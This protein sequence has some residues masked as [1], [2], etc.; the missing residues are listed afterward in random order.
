MPLGWEPM[1][2]GSASSGLTRGRARAKSVWSLVAAVISW[3]GLMHSYR[4]TVADTVVNFGWGTG[5]PWA[6]GYIMLAIL[7]FYVDWQERRKGAMQSLK[8]PK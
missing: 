6:I 7:L 2:G 4:W 8:S 5:A 3:V 1:P